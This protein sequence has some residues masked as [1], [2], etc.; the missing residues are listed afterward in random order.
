MLG[1]KTNNII[2]LIIMIFVNEHKR[3]LNENGVTMLIKTKDVTM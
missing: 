3:K 2:Q 1:E